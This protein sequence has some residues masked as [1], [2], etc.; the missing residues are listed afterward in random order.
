M[1]TFKIETLVTIK[2]WFS[3]RGLGSMDT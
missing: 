3:C 1:E 2:G